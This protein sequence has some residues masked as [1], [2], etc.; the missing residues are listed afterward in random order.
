MML[1]YDSGDNVKRRDKCY[2]LRFGKVSKRP[3]NDDERFFNRH[4][5]RP[6]QYI[7]QGQERFRRFRVGYNHFPF[8]PFDIDFRS[9]L[10]NEI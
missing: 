2:P 8:G 4:L 7:K 6:F 10:K 3:A 5:L 9:A 1:R